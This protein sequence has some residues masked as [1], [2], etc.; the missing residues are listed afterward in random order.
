MTKARIYKPAKNAMQSG[1]AKNLWCLAYEAEKP[2]SVSALTGHTSS[3]DPHQQIV[4]SFPT[5]DAAIAYAQRNGIDFQLLPSKERKRI[6]KA[7][8]DNFATARIEGNWT[9]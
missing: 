5:Q 3:S 4:I 1:S 6:I 7:Y 9:H 8:S 2:K